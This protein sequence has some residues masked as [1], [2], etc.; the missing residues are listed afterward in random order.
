MQIHRQTL[1]PL[2]GDIRVRPYNTFGGDI[3]ERL[4]DFGKSRDGKT[5]K[6]RCDARLQSKKHHVDSEAPIW[7]GY[8]CWFVWNA[9]DLT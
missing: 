1:I 4:C 7:M 8:S 6:Q 9:V 3:R 5:K 2:G